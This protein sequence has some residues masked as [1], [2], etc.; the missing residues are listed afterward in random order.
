MAYLRLLLEEDPVNLA[1]E[2]ALVKP[3]FRS[4]WSLTPDPPAHCRKEH[5]AAQFGQELSKVAAVHA[6]IENAWE[7]TNPHLHKSPSARRPFAE[8]SGSIS[9]SPPVVPFPET[10]PNFVCHFKGSL[11]VW[12]EPRSDHCNELMLL[13][14]VVTVVELSRVERKAA[15]E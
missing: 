7:W 12:G 14:G 8:I 13:A 9:F 10:V 4:G 1:K 5:R 15:L 11:Q 6:K 2:W 3:F